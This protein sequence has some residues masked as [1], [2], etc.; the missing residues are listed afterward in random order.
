MGEGSKIVLTGDPE[1]IAD[2]FLDPTANGLVHV[3]ERMKGKDAFGHIT[4]KKTERSRLAELGA[5]LL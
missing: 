2:A 1:Q 3:I 5:E 4:M